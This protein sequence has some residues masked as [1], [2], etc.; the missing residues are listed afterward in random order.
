MAP[1]GTASMARR[2]PGRPAGAAGPAGPPRAW[3]PAPGVT[4]RRAAGGRYARARGRALARAGPRSRA[5]LR[6][7]AR[8]RRPRAGP[9]QGGEL[10]PGRR[11]VAARRGLQHKVEPFP[12]HPQVDVEQ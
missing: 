5:R 9:P 1:T 6:A 2:V 3:T 7:L 4:R 11:A 10:V 8:P 12:A